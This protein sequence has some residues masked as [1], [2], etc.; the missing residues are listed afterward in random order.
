[1][2]LLTIPEAADNYVSA[3]RAATKVREKW[4]MA[5]TELTISE[6]NYEDILAVVK[7]SKERLLSILEHEVRPREVK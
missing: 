6:K 7:V 4:E 2:A 3:C 5:K 1:M